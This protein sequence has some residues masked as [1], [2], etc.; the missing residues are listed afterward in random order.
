MQLLTKRSMIR[1]RIGWAL[2]ERLLP[3]NVRLM[4][5]QS[6]PLPCSPFCVA[7]ESQPFLRLGFLVSMIGLFVPIKQGHCWLI[8]SS[9]D[10]LM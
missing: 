2:G 4:P 10:R 5:H 1:A 8:W 9:I 7:K 3:S 6:V